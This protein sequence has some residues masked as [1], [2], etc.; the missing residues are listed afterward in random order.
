MNTSGSSCKSQVSSDR[1]PCRWKE[2]TPF[3]ASA[4]PLRPKGWTDAFSVHR[5]QPPHARPP[6]PRCAPSDLSGLLRQVF[7]AQQGEPCHT[8]QKPALPGLPV[9]TPLRHTRESLE[10]LIPVPAPEDYLSQL[11]RPPHSHSQ[12]SLFLK[13]K[14]EGRRGGGKED[15]REEGKSIVG[16]DTV[17]IYIQ[18]HCICIW[19]DTDLPPGRLHTNDRPFYYLKTSLQ[20]SASSDRGRRNTRRSTPSHFH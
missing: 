10:T 1:S 4:F 20:G 8:A 5:A 19:G 17:V 7:S 18:T 6:P 11:P 13:K 2:T 9:S 15:K 3:Q 14:R 12:C 16:Q